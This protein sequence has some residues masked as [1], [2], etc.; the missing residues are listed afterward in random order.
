MDINLAA[1][2]AA[3]ALHRL[4]TTTLEAIEGMDEIT[5]RLIDISA[6]RFSTLAAE[7]KVQIRKFSNVI[8]LV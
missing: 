7:S 6:E 1:C 3:E 5:K 4:L 8:D 2:G